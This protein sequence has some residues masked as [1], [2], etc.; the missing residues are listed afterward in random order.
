MDD[1]CPPV[2]LCIRSRL[3]FIL[4]TG[5]SDIINLVDVQPAVN[6]G[7]PQDEKKKRT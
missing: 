7:V 3:L 2:D 4:Q 6:A 1:F 5:I